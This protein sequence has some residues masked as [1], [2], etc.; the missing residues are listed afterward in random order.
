HSAVEAAIRCR[1]TAAQRNATIRPAGT[2]S[3]TRAGGIAVT[4]AIEAAV[5]GAFDGL[6]EPNPDADAQ[7]SHL[8]GGAALRDSFLARRDQVGD[9]ANH[10]AVRIESFDHA[11]ADTVDVTFSILIDGA[12][13]LDALPGQAKLVDDTWLVSTK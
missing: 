10:T 1:T 12:V 13:V 9:L 3:T 4:P 6:F 2:P 5:T 8:E 11:T 7:L